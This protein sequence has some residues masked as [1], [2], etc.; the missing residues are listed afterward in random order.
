MFSPISSHNGF[1]HSNTIESINQVIWVVA[2]QSVGF[3]AEEQYAISSRSQTLGISCSSPCVHHGP[4]GDRDHNNLHIGYDHDQDYDR[5]LTAQSKGMYILELPCQM[6]CDHCSNETLKCFVLS[7][8]LPNIFDTR[9]WSSPFLLEAMD[10][11][12]GIGNPKQHSI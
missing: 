7:C 5:G 10:S 8:V 2:S 1:S 12:C 4:A 3:Q 6:Y 9:F 11:L